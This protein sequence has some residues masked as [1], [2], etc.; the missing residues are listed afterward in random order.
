LT[1][2][3]VG[4]A[5][6]AI[7]G[8]TCS[9]TPLSHSAFRSTSRS[10][11]RQHHGAGGRGRGQTS[12][13]CSRVSARHPN[14]TRTPRLHRD[15][16]R[17]EIGIIAQ[18][19]THPHP[20]NVA[21]GLR[22]A[23]VAESAPWSRRRSARRLGS[24]LA[25]A[26]RRSAAARRAR[27]LA[28][29]APLLLDGPVLARSRPGAVRGGPAL[30]QRLTA[31]GTSPHSPVEAIVFAIV[32][33]RAGRVAR[34]GTRG[35]ASTTQVLVRGG[36]GRDRGSRGRA[37]DLLADHSTADGEFLEEDAPVRHRVLT[38]SPQSLPAFRNQRRTP[39][40]L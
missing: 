28:E 12:C 18:D 31:C 7:S 17:R 21:F 2:H 22:A 32:G 37:A 24:R 13:A 9:R 27:A 1:G 39:Q 38:V 33:A 35:P 25:P 20:H 15:P 11:T 14:A 5:L 16:W 6:R 8:R 4:S 3:H 23:G 40:R 26:V 29:P 10:G 19:F 30:L 34:A 36:A